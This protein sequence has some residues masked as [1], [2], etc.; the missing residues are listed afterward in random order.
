MVKILNKEQRKR[1]SL[2]GGMSGLLV[3]AWFLFFLKD[4]F[5]FI[6]ALAGALILIWGWKDGK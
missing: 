6:P 2:W 1:A 5:G 3:G 4:N